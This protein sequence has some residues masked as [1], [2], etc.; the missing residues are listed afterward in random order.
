MMWPCPGLGRAQLSCTVVLAV[1]CVTQPLEGQGIADLLY[2]VREILELVCA[3]PVLAVLHPAPLQAE[4]GFFSDAVFQA[5]PSWYAAAEGSGQSWGKEGTGE[6]TGGEGRGVQ[7]TQCT[8]RGAKVVLGCK[9]SAD[10]MP[11]PSR[12]GPTEL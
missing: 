1:G 6:G 2:L 9:D 7:G 12:Q 11:Y 3:S 10:W 5:H 8:C 4:R